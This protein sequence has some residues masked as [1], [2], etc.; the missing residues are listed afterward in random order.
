[1]SRYTIG[2]TMRTTSI[3]RIKDLTERGWWGDR[4]LD[5]LFRAAVES[6]PNHVALVDQFNRSEFTDGEAQRLTYAEL[7]NVAD[8]LAAAFYEYGLRQ[9]DIVVLQLPNIA[10]LA[11]LYLALGKLGVILSPVPIQYG[12]FELE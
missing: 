3:E 6:C 7:A 9:D 4:T 8:N 5:T 11:A 2:G 10:E 1:V 12:P